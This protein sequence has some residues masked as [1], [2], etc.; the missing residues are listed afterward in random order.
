MEPTKVKVKKGLNRS[1]GSKRI[2]NFETNAVVVIVAVIIATILVFVMFFSALAEFRRQLGG[3][4]QS[5]NN[6]LV[7]P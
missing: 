5:V 7:L 6:N 3:D 1:K 2:A 4:S